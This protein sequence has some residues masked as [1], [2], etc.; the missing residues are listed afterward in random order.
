L[1]ILSEKIG[2]VGHQ[3][4]CFYPEPKAIDAGQTVG[5]PPPE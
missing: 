4:A 5:E 3:A 2:A 1:P